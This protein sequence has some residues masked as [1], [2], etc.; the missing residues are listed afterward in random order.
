MLMQDEKEVSPALRQAVA[1]LV[2]AKAAVDRLSLGDAA[3]RALARHCTLPSGEDGT[4]FFREIFPFCGRWEPIG[5][6]QAMQV[7]LEQTFGHSWRWWPKHVAEE[8]KASLRDQL[9]AAENGKDRAEVC[10]IVPLGLY[11]AH[12]GKNRIAF[13]REEG[14]SHYPALTT[15]YGY[16]APDQLQ[17]FLIPGPHGEEC[18]AVLDDDLIEPLHCPEWTLPVLTAYGVST[19]K[20]WPEDY[21]P[22]AAVR[23]QLAARS[24]R[25]FRPLLEAPVSLAALQAKEDKAGEVVTTSFM[26]LPGVRLRRGW[27]IGLATLMA[28][29]LVGILVFQPQLHDLSILSVGLGAALMLTTFVFGEILAV[30]R[31]QLDSQDS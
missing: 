24:G 29:I 21:P 8:H 15:P 19:S 27:K 17:I 3:D 16:P 30:P 28:T 23:D 2:N 9:L 4:S 11:L 22:Y 12:E 6:S 7:P 20:G 14:V 13:L 5:A 26:D 31:H 25:N 18:W 10:W 1:A